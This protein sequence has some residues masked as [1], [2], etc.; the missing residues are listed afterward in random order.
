M[1]EVELTIYTHPT[2]IKSRKSMLMSM[3]SVGDSLELDCVLDCFWV[4]R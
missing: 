1:K 3:V 4:D 2:L